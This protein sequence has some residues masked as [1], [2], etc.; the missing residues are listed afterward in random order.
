MSLI[1]NLDN[2]FND[3]CNPTPRW[4]K[5]IVCL[6]CILL[7]CL[8]FYILGT[9]ETEMTLS[10]PYTSYGDFKLIGD[11]AN[12]GALPLLTAL[13]WF[14]SLMIFTTLIFQVLQGNRAAII[15][16]V[17]VAAIAILIILLV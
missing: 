6:I 10:G 14:I 2:E 3:I 7:G 13:I 5:F 4:V 12:P 11:E 16:A 9:V 1:G 15:P 8:F 17:I